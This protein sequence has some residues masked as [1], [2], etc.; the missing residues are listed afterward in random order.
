MGCDLQSVQLALSIQEAEALKAYLG[1]Q[2]LVVLDEAQNIPDVG[3]IL[4]ILVDT[5]PEMQVLATGSSSFDLANK[6]SEALT[7]RVYPFEL[8]PLS[9]S[10]IAGAQGLSVIELHLERML[11]FGLYPSL[12]GADED[13]ARFQLEE[14]VSNYLYKDVLAYIGVK[15][16]SAVAGLLRLLALQIGQ[17][18]AYSELGGRWALIGAQWRTTSTCSNRAS[19]SFG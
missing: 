9:L 3:R 5:Y 7:G 6:T 1:E 14:S 16:S 18:V 13:E 15:K 12:W 4:K 19:W 11:R 10:E 8:F 17:E 2:D